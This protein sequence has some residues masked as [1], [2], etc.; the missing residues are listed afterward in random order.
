VEK[1]SEAAG[2]R[3]VGAG[4]AED[5]GNVA[6]VPVPSAEE[7]EEVEVEEEECVE[8]ACEEENQRRH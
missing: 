7:E 1:T 5:V 6:A 4:R 2:V 3:V 8:N